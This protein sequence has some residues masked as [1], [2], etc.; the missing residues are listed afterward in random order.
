MQTETITVKAG[1]NQAITKVVSTL[2]EPTQ[3]KVVVEKNATADIHLVFTQ[4]EKHMYS[5][6]LV[7]AGEGASATLGGLVYGVGE[8][9]PVTDILISHVAPQTKARV[10]FRGVMT[11][12]ARQDWRGMIKIAKDAQQTDSW[13]EDRTLLLSPKARATAIPSLEIEA[14]DVH[15]SHAATVGK[16]DANVLLYLATRGIDEPTAR[17]LIIDGFIRP[18]MPA[19]EQAHRA[20]D[21]LVAK[22]F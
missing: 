8:N 17:R 2:S 13:L 11:G 20:L 1:T 12:S 3:V 9:T 15:A 21:A 18:V 5:F 16:L 22:S 10:V 14:N 6:E 7:L 19:D 4:A